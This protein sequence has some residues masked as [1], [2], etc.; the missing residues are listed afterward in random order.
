MELN[1]ASIGSAN[2]LK[3]QFSNDGFGSV[4]VDKN[5]DG[6]KYIPTKLGIALDLKGEAHIRQASSDG[7]TWFW[8]K[9]KATD[10]GDWANKTEPDEKDLWIMI[11]KNPDMVCKSYEHVCIEGMRMRHFTKFRTPFVRIND[12]GQILPAII[13]EVY[14]HDGRVGLWL[15]R[16][17][18]GHGGHLKFYGKVDLIVLS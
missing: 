14:P 18:L 8:Y 15:G 11:E 5:C 13:Y 9:F 7:I 3:I 4:A 6:L 17:S 1:T 16:D 2:R 12:S 10:L